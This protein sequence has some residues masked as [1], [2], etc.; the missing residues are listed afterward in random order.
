MYIR[1]EAVSLA[2][3]LCSVDMSAQIAKDVIEARNLWSLTSKS[4]QKQVISG[5]RELFRRSEQTSYALKS[6][7][8]APAFL[9]FI[10]R[11]MVTVPC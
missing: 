11:R 5:L 10:P 7:I 4:A 1:N 6:L 3:P 8:L 2:I 9:N